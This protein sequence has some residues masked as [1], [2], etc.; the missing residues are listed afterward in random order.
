MGK[1]SDKRIN[2]V[3]SGSDMFPGKN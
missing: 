1:K 3:K 2:S